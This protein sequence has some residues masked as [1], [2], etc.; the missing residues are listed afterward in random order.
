[1][2]KK[3]QLRGHCQAC[4][5]VQAVPGRLAKHG[6]KVKHG[7]F[8]GTCPGSDEQPMETDRSVTDRYITEMRR[9]ALACRTTAAKLT[10]GETHPRQVKTNRFDPK[11]RECVTVSWEEA[12]PYQRK[13]AI[14][15]AVMQQNQRADLA[16]RCATELE[17]LASRIHGRE[18]ETVVMKVLEPLRIGEKRRGMNSILEAIDMRNARVYWI[19]ER[20]YKG[21]S[22]A[23]AWRKL[24]LVV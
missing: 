22:G 13:D 14:D 16:E 24:P 23:G 10:N 9:D 11:T 21:W 5:R 1:M 4:G 12:S 19:N 15:L 17:S 2:E 8:Q 6:Y 18:L 20:G 3:T 7:W